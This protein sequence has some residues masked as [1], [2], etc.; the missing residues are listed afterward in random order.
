MSG[1][2]GTINGLV[3]SGGCDAVSVPEFENRN[4]DLAVTKRE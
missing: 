3:S 1:R 4:G 2:D